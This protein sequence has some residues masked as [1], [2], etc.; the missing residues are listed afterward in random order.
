MQVQIRL[1]DLDFD[2][3]YEQRSRLLPILVGH[4]DIPTHADQATF[5]GN[6][7]GSLYEQMD[8]QLLTWALWEND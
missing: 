5:T 3:V 1:F 2:I 6:I 4:C 7:V 8:G